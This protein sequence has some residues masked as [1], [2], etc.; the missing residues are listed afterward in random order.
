MTRLLRYTLLLVVLA[1]A[2]IGVLLFSLTWRPDTRETLP[3]SCT[4]TPL[5]WC[6]GKR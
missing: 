2:L 3:V 5:R 4:G 6:P 1:I